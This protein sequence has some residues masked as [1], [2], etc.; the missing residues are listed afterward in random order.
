[1]D[2]STVT[3]KCL[4]WNDKVIFPF[5]LFICNEFNLL[6]L[7]PLSI[8]LTNWTMYLFIYYFSS[9]GFCTEL[10]ILQNSWE[11]ILWD[12]SVNLTLN[13]LENTIGS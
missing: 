4:C 2:N 12:S 9:S 7:N 6:K 5:V 3:V 11:E 8:K 1:M 10:N 13:P